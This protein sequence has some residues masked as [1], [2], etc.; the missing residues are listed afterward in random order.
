[1]EDLGVLAE[2]IFKLEK[3]SV[4]GPYRQGDYFI[5]VQVLGVLPARQKTFAE[6][7][8]DIEQTLLPLF[9]QRALQERLKE[10]RR[11]L[12]IAIDQDGL[13][14]VKSPLL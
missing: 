1:M 12:A 10:L 7:T 2:E 9:R 5:L 11:P 14:K 13:Q 3:G 8:T 4:G 6:A